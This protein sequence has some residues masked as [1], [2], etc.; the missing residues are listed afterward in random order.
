M[1]K[2]L[3]KM[4][5]SPHD[6]WTISDV[7]AVCSAHGLDCKPPRGGGSHYSVTHPALR[8]I[9]TVPSRRPIKAVYIRKLV[10]MIDAIRT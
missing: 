8:D 5:A 7:Q 3:E 6:N 2:R 10:K 9:L 1:D 4:R